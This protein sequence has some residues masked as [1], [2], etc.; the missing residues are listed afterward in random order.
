MN[1]EQRLAELEQ[2]VAELEKK[3]AEGTTAEVTMQGNVAI[4]PE[5]FQAILDKAPIIDLNKAQNN[6]FAEP[7]KLYN[8]S[9]EFGSDEC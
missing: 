8:V 4:T 7:I 3:A 9:K 2:R 5:E 6:L 1:I